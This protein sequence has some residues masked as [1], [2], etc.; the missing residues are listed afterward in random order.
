M[1]EVA[2]DNIAKDY[3]IG[4][5]R[6]RIATDYCSGVTPEEVRK[7]FERIATTVKRNFVVAETLGNNDVKNTAIT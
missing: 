1:V 3:K 5:T 7:V 4:N 2:T 6:V